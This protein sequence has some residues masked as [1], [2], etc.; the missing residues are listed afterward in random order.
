[1][2]VDRVILAIDIIGALVCIAFVLG[3]EVGKRRERGVWSQI[4]K[5][6]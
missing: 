1:M 2:S 3:I 6:R 5:P 4:R